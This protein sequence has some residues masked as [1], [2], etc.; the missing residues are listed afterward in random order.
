[1]T[2][3]VKH[4]D[5]TAMEAIRAA[6][7]DYPSRCLLPHACNAIVGRVF[8]LSVAAAEGTMSLE[9]AQEELAGHQA[10]VADA[11]P[12]GQNEDGRG[13]LSHWRCGLIEAD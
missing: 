1:M 13:E 3:T 7:E 8:R 6:Q 4:F 11:C 2:E 9:D 10:Y 12:L 5:A